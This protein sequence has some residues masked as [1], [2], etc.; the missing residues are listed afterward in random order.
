LVLK[1]KRYKRLSEDVY[2]IIEMLKHTNGWYH[3]Y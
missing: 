2:E 3:R 1:E